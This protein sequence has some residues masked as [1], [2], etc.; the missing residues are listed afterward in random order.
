MFLLQVL[1]PMIRINTGNIPPEE[2]ALAQFAQSCMNN[3]QSTVGNT[4]FLQAY[5]HIRMAIQTVRQQES[6]VR[7]NYLLSNQ[8]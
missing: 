7:N 6:L 4:L 2:T 5:Q 3:I 1:H 8:H